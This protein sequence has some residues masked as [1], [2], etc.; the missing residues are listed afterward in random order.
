VSDLLVIGN[1]N[2]PSSLTFRISALF[3]AAVSQIN[4][5]GVMKKVEAIRNN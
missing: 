3:A 5:A 2:K 1:G 4:L